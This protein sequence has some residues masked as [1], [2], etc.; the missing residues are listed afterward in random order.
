MK[1]KRV[2]VLG[3]YG[4]IGQSV[5]RR[6]IDAGHSVLALGRDAKHGKHHEARCD[7]IAA[8]ISNLTSMDKWLPLLAGVDA[9]V[10][11]S[12]AL[13]SGLRDRLDDLQNRSIVALIEACE[14]ASVRT[15]VQIS[16]PGATADAKTEFLRTKSVADARL[17]ESDLAWVILKPGL[18]ISPNAYGG[19]ALLRMLAAFPVVLPLVHGTVPVGTVDIEDVSTT[20]VMAVERTILPASEIDI[21]ETDPGS[22]RDVALAFRKWLG[23]PAPKAVISVPSWAG[24]LVGRGADVL[25]RLGWRSPLRS[26]ALDVIKDGVIADNSAFLSHVGRTPRSLEETLLRIPSTVQERWFAQ[27]YL[28]IPIVLATLSAFW[29][30]SGAVGLASI[31]Q[32]TGHVTALGMSETVAYAIVASGAAVDIALGAAV[33]FQ[34]FARKAL[35]AMAAVTVGYLAAG[36]VLSPELWADPLGPYVKTI[37]AAVLALLASRFIRSR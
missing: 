24:T 13:Q 30:V 25:G 11:A 14:K 27:L 17:R 16:A 22:L 19:T 7:W 37:P 28:A 34:P 26:T 2:L 21:I 31:G 12:G 10:N 18:V 33:L 8:D 9:V 3:G 15:F 5:V 6:L 32:A 1:Q 36:T 23:L 29:I 35:L 20:V 4:L